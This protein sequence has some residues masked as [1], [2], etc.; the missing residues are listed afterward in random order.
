MKKPPIGGQRRHWRWLL[1]TQL[2][3]V[4]SNSWRRLPLPENS[5][6]PSWPDELAEEAFYGLAGD[7]VRTIEPETEADPAALLVQFLVGIGNV[8]GRGPHFIADAARHALNLF[9][10]LVGTTSKAR[11][12]TSWGHIHHLLATCD[13]DWS[14]KCIQTGLSSGEGLIHAVRDEGVA[15]KR[16]LVIESEFASTLR[17]LDRDGN[18]L[19]PTLRQSWD[20]GKLQVM[21]K[22]FPET[23]T[24]AHVSIIGHVTRDELRREL[25][26]TDKGN[27][28]ANRILWVCARRSKVLPE[29]GQVPQ[30]E[31]QRLSKKL[32]AVLKHGR[33]LREHEF[34]S[35]DGAGFWWREIYAELSEGKL[36]LFGAVTSRAEAQVMRMASLYAVLDIAREIRLEHLLAAEAV[37]KYCEASARFVFGNALGD[38]LADELLRLLR[39]S[40][41]GLT[42]TEL[43]NALGRNKAAEHIGRALAL[44]AEYGLAKGKR[45]ETSGRSAERWS[46][47]C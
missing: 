10:V 31:L 30:A 2:P 16:L 29:G 40:P 6:I 32:Q 1:A 33:S 7:V 22:Q 14:D 42:R 21:T 35:D 41:H 19:S 25:T 38:P 37:W 24:G 47:V 44:L 11:K 36:G 46:A 20:G 17:V 15:D 27:G 9:T 45:E 23:S 13:T 34:R 4:D 43:N 12:G 18:T 26:R 5:Q 8:I 28:F 3:V 39:Q